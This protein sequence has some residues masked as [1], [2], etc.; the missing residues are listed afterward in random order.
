MR[1]TPTKKVGAIS[2]MLSATVSIDSAK[3]TVPPST[4][5]ITSE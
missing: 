1:G 5:C 3:L 2:R 4:N